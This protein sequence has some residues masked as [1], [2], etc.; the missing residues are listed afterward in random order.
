MKTFKLLVILC[1]V[2]SLLVGGVADFITYCDP[3]ECLTADPCT[4]PSDEKECELLLQLSCETRRLYHSLDCE[5]KN[6]AIALSLR[7]LDKES[8][9][10]QAAR[11]MG[12]RQWEQYPNQLDYEEQIEDQTGQNAYERRFGD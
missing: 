9:V 8:A 4:P 3:L 12:R 2:P 7:S 6:R 1:W 5:G 10:E 11:E